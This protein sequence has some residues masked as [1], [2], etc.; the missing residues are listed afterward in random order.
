MDRRTV[1]VLVEKLNRDAELVARRFGL[2]Y[3]SIEAERATVKS[4]YGVC[5]ADGGIKIRLRHAVTGRALKY[6]SLVNTLCHE[7]AHLRHFDHG[8]RFKAFYLQLLEFARAEG[9][10]RPGPVEKPN[11]QRAPLGPVQLGLFGPR[12]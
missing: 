12:C 2:S 10:Y 1:R 5:S 11:P 8:E 9:I 3:R 4:R 7:L 6:S